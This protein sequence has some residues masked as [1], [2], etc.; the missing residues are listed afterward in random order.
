MNKIIYHLYI[1]KKK[2]KS[3][4]FAPY[5]HMFILTIDQELWTPELMCLIM[6]CDHFLGLKKF[7]DQLNLLYI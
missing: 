2:F 5:L 1:F 4:L 7:L 6:G 3:T